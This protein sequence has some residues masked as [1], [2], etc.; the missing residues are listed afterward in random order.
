MSIARFARR[1]RCPICNGADSDPRGKGIRCFGFL[2]S[3]GK[4][5]HCSRVLCGEQENGG[6]WAHRLSGNCDCGTMHGEAPPP[7]HPAPLRQRQVTRDV[8]RIWSGLA[9]S[10][11]LGEA[12]LESRNLWDDGLPR[13]G[14]FRFN[15]GQSCDSWL[16]ARAAEGY[17][18][19]FA[20]RRPDGAVQTIILRHVGVGIEG[21]GKAPALPGCSTSGAAICRPEIR[22]LIEGSSE[23][24]HDEIALVEGPTSFLAFT[25]LRDALYR[26]GLVR[27][28]WTLG[29]IGAGQAV[30]VVEAFAPIIAGRVLRIA[31]DA[32]ET[33]DRN[34]RLAAEAAFR[35]GALRMLRSKPRGGLKDVAD[36]WRTA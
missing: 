6:T 15:A 26:D 19:A 8:P 29:C 24:E 12:Y 10:D 21:F 22:F 16:N 28:S 2:S 14:F 11:R 17:R 4:Y 35:V 3:D 18:C 23:F 7:L 36:L 27:P 34:A 20:A 31:L 25:L 5:A 33:G 32:D 9:L 13:T 30:S 1:L